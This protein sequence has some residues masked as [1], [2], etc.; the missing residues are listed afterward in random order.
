M[1]VSVCVFVNR[2]SWREFFVRRRK[3]RGKGSWQRLGIKGVG[4]EIGE[5]AVEG[6]MDEEKM[7]GKCIGENQGENRMEVL[8]TALRNNE[9]KHSRGEKYLGFSLR[10]LSHMWHN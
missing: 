5:D 10:N 7:K 3:V 1:F 4:R 2:I 8:T 9:N 6:K